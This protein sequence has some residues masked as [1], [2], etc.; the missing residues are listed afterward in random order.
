MSWKKRLLAVPTASKEYSIAIE[1][2]GR[3]DSFDPQT[4]SVV[5]VEASRLRGKLDAYYR[6]AGAKAPIV[7]ELP[8]G[9]LRAGYSKATKHEPRFRR[10]ALDRGLAV[11]QPV[12]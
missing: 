7:I 8:R 3:D 6:E 10:P 9:G 4:S 5:R 1:V 11:Q 12:E 2:F